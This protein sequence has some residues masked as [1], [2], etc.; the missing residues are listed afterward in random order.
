VF[1]KENMEL[2]PFRRLL[3][4]F[5]FIVD[6]LRGMETAAVQIQSVLFVR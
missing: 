3:K 2:F 6:M 1:L 4:E 5:R